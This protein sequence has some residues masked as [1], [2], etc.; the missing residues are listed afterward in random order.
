M[1]FFFKR[2][3]MCLD[4]LQEM[5]RKVS[6]IF[7]A[8]KNSYKPNDASVNQPIRM[9]ILPSPPPPPPILYLVEPIVTTVLA[10]AD[11]KSIE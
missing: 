2:K 8:N 10:R 4:K 11:R 7:P 3:N 5:Q 1:D 9:G 6:Y